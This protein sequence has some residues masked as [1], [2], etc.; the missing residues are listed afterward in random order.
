MSEEYVSFPADLS[1]LEAA[2]S[3]MENVERVDQEAAEGKCGGLKT[4]MANN[5]G[6]VNDCNNVSYE[7]AKRIGDVA[8]AKCNA[9]IQQSCSSL[10]CRVGQ[11]QTPIWRFSCSNNMY[12]AMVAVKYTC[13]E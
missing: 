7:E 8:A 6:P 10:G 1:G 11:T 4:A 5:R 2:Q 3:D 12:N 13:T 9:L